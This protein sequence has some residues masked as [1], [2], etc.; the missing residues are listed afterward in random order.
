MRF[1][2]FEQ[3]VLLAMLP[4][5]EGIY[6]FAPAILFWEFRHE[7][8]TVHAVKCT[9]SRLANVTNF[10]GLHHSVSMRRAA[11]AP[12]NRIMNVGYDANANTDVGQ[13]SKQKEGTTPQLPSDGVDKPALH[14]RHKLAAVC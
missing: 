8:F 6:C 7:S 9:C 11:A 10:I 3:F 2:F 12:F 5:D 4:F 13:S 1:P 14:H